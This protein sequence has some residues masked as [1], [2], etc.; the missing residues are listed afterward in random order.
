MQ[1]A[2]SG[3]NSLFCSWGDI[4]WPGARY[5]LRL[6][7]GN[8]TSGSAPLNTRTFYDHSQVLASQVQSRPRRSTSNEEVGKAKAM[9]RAEEV[10]KPVYIRF[11][12]QIHL[13][14]LQAKGGKD[15]EKVRKTKQDLMMKLVGSK[16]TNQVKANQ[17]NE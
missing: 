10:T 9:W 8:I 12:N 11:C 16:A 17:G 1:T 2:A 4:R 5:N 13:F 7:P 15:R 14:G 3:T 6:R